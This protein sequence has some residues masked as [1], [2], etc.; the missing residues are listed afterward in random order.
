MERIYSLRM[1]DKVVVNS[2]ITS[3]IVSSVATILSFIVAVSISFYLQR[4]KN[5]LTLL[6]E[7]VF[8]VSAY[9]PPV[10]IGLVVFLFL[11]ILG[12]KLR[13]MTPVLHLLHK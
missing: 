7:K 1:I 9:L 5:R 10:L 3:I 4:Y 8:Y 6:L 2:I 11:S 12:E 13:F